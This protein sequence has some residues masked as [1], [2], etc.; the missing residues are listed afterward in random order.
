MTMSPLRGRRGWE[1]R[2]DEQLV[3]VADRVDRA[4]RRDKYGERREDDEG[5]APQT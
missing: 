4:V 5:D 2:V 3:V 1:R